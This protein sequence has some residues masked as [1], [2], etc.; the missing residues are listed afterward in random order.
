MQ[1]LELCGIRTCV[2]CMV[3]V[4]EM[5]QKF[6]ALDAPVL[7]Q[8][9]TGTGKELAARALHALSS[10]SRKPLVTVDCAALAE[11]LVESE[12]F[13]HERGAFTGA[14]RAY[15]GRVEA[16]AG[17]SLF[18]DEINSMSLLLQGKLLRF[19]ED[20][21]I[22]RIGRERTLKVDVRVITASN[23]TLK[24]LVAEGL[25]RADFFYRLS[26]F[27]VHLPPLRERLDDI[28]LLV[29]QFLKEDPLARRCGVEDVSPDVLDALRAHTWPGNVRELRNVL[30]RSVALGEEGRLLRRCEVTA[31][32]PSAPPEVASIPPP[33]HQVHFRAWI[34]EREREYLLDLIRRHRGAS[35]QAAVSGL[36]QRTLYRKIRGLHLGPGSPQLTSAASELARAVANCSSRSADRVANAAAT[37]DAG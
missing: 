16:A 6:S 22:Q 18:L 15:T 24:Q 10:L 32:P 3:P 21:E 20:G 17:G 8:G 1:E 25:M 31:S 23:A 36:P 34:R 37:R 26:A 35:E 7:I 4:L 29:R 30:R 13:G 33:P 2:P 9:E 12:L 5:I 14:D 27:S 11:T 19:L 28:P